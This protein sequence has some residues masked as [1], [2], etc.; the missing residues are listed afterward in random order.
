MGVRMKTI[1]IIAEYNPFHQGHKYL[2]EEAKRITG[3]QRLV[4]VMSGNSVQRGDFALV[5][6]F[7]R[8]EEAVGQG[9]DLVIGLPFCYSSQSA[10]YFAK[11]ATSILNSLGITDFLCYGSEHNELVSQRGIANLL[12]KKSIEILEL[13]QGMMKT[14]ISFPVAREQ[15][16]RQI[17]GKEYNYDIMA[18]PNDILAIEYL[19]SLSKLESQIE[20]VS[21]KRRGSNHNDTDFETSMPSA[22]AIRSMILDKGSLYYHNLDAI[23]LSPSDMD[24]ELEKIKEMELKTLESVVPSKL[25]KYIIGQK[26]RDSLGT[27]ENYLDEIKA[28]FITRRASLDQI[29]EVGEGIEN[30][31]AKHI[32]QADSLHEL[33][34]LAK[35][36]RFAYTRIRRILMNILIGLTKEDMILVKDSKDIP[37]GRLLAFNDQGRNMLK[38]IKEHGQI[39]LI[40]KM[41]DF[42]PQSQLHEVLLKYDNLVDELYYWKYQYIHQ[43][44]RVHHRSCTSPRYVRLKKGD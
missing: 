38:E 20:P 19:K 34:L 5:D 18:T 41:S 40:N 16:V 39:T 1:G 6:E 9:A 36:K 2:I 27:L 26:D 10:E 24:L 25:A 8:A 21:V 4:V 37:Y 22:S 35:S 43:G 29:F 31:L 14:G 13:T 44:K 17:G 11:G 23:P 30:A 33:I 12:D 3:A 15:A 7:I 42:R 32:H 28:L